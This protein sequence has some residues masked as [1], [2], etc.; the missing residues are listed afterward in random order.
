MRVCNVVVICLVDFVWFHA[1]TRAIIFLFLCVELF[2]SQERPSEEVTTTIKG[3]KETLFLPP[4]YVVFLLT[5]TNT[6][7]EIQMRER[8][9]H[10]VVVALQKAETL[11]EL[12]L[13]DKAALATNRT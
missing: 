4:H 13:A 3:C 2:A 6:V 8:N 11:T 7:D 5:H 1:L 12:A 10:D 9:D